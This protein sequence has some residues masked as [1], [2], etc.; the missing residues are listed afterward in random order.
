MQDTVAI[1]AFPAPL[2]WTTPPEDW[3]V[4]GEDTLVVSAGGGT[5]LFTDP[6]GSA[7]F[8]N[9]PALVGRVEGDFSL[10]ARVRLDLASTYDAAVL[11]LWAG[12]DTWAKFC[13]E[14]SPQ[15]RP[16]IV[17]VV[18]RGVSD[19]CNSFA[20]DG[21]DVRLRISRLGPAYAFHVR[22][23]G[24]FWHLVRYFALDGDPEVGFLAQ[25]PTG[26]GRTV[27]FEEIAFTPTRLADLR[28]GT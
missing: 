19:D 17:S 11:L 24:D 5:D 2:R 7:R 15:G 21:G 18:N 14:A 10:S 27:R 22:A 1:P 4:E 6:D 26:E 16:T 28:G 13:L 8:A 9:A 20:V 25:S 3:S 23:D 12:A